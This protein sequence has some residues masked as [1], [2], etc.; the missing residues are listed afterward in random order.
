MLLD[1]LVLNRVSVTGTSLSDNIGVAG[2]LEAHEESPGVSRPLDLGHWRAFW[3][4]DR[5][6]LL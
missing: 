4:A 6:M 5:I 1:V 2:S 3:I